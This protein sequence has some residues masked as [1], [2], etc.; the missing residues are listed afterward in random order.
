MMHA[1]DSTPLHVTSET[2]DGWTTV[3]CGC[4]FGNV[5]GTFVIEP[6]SVNCRILDLVK[7]LGEEAEI[8]LTTLD[9]RGP[10]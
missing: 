4:Q 6:C 9:L 8:P 10:R 2:P 7:D 5:S 1:N 3:S